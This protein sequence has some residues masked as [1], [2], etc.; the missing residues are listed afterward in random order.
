MTA[1]NALVSDEHVYEL[2][3]DVVIIRVYHVDALDELA[4]P[5]AAFGYEQHGALGQLECTGVEV[6]VFAFGG[7]G[8]FV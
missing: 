6:F 8:E 1:K 5:H 7:E 4:L 3:A 2:W